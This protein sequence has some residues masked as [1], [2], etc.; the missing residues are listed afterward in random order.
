MQEQ[1]EN[2]TV[3]SLKRKWNNSYRS[4]T[5]TWAT[6]RRKGVDESNAPVA[7]A[8]GRR[9]QHYGLRK[10]K[11][12][13]DERRGAA[14]A[15][16]VQTLKLIETLTK[17]CKL[18]YGPDPLP[19]LC[20]AHSVAMRTPLLLILTCPLPFFIH[21]PKHI[22]SKAH[23]PFFLIPFCWTNILFYFYHFIFII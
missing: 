14:E 8:H 15:K 9:D 19:T 10:T 18:V 13:R 20:Q 11:R 12:T 21:G 22:N 16:N 1:N 3:K 2:K 23:H 7:R 5:K 17:L 6:V 4:S